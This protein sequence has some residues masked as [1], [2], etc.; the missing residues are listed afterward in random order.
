MRCYMDSHGGRDRS[1]GSPDW[2]VSVW[3]WWRALKKH[4]IRKV[5]VNL[6]AFIKLNVLKTLLQ[7][8]ILRTLVKQD[9]AVVE[10]P[11][12]EGSEEE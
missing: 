4:R 6:L 7:M 12:T 8:E 9:E 11:K 2:C 10:E 3:G 1:D 5:K